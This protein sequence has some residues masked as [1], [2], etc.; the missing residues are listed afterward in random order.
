MRQVLL[1]DFGSTYTKLTAVNLDAP[2]V[3]AH[4]QTRTTADSDLSIG[5]NEGLALLEAQAGP[6]RFEARLACSS[7]AGGLNMV[8]SGLVPNLTAKAAKLAA[9]GAG[10]KV[11]RTYAYQLTREDAEEIAGIRP[12][13]L[14]LTGGTDGGNSEVIIHNARRVSGIPSNFPVIVA[15]NRS[16]REKCA[17][18][19]MKSTHP[20]FCADNVMPEMNRLVIEP[21]QR[22][23]RQ[24]FLER[25]ISA[26]GLSE[27]QA[28]LD[29]ILMPTPSAVL[30]GL[31]LLAGG[32]NKH[33]GIGDL[34]AV[35]LG[36]AT[37]DVYSIAD[38]FPTGAN[39]VLRGLIEPRV[40]RTVEG[41]IGMR[42]GAR[43]VLEAAGSEAFTRLTGLPEEAVTRVIAGYSARPEALP[44]N[45]E[46][47]KVDFA[48]AVLAIRTALGRHAGTLEKVYTPVGPMYQQ[49]GKDL[50]GARR[51]VVTGGALIY[52]G[53]LKDIV[54]EALM[55]ADPLV[56]TPRDAIISCDRGYIL[57]AMGLLSGYDQDAALELLLGAFGKEEE[58]AAC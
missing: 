43:G 27:T 13:I 48:L 47:E 6:F 56:L 2:G 33:A 50:S 8:A 23:I 18:I 31:K 41:D 24:V 28:L 22:V 25:I 26:K 20:V 38:G 7:A 57:S 42:F 21:V 16:A 12:D 35:D 11:I 14:L 54:R 30:E 55:R 53:N 45:E 51:L 39:T 49:T 5:L 15:G 4:A 58:N 36:G 17:D 1:I 46:E 34:V 44:A 10:A 19:L 3:L 29:G 32:S 40:K 52:A 9:F 37:T